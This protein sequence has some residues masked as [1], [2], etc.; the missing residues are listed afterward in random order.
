MSDAKMFL[1]D[2]TV[3]EML[4]DSLFEAASRNEISDLLKTIPYE[5]TNE[6]LDNA[7]FNLL[8]NC[9]SEEQAETLKEIRQCWDFLTQN[10]TEEDLV[11]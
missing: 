6:E 4:R 8:L 2:L 5:F 7:Y 1:K 3:S 10:T 11:F 9:R